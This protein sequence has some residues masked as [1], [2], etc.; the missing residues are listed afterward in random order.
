MDAARMTASPQ[1]IAGMP[2]RRDG[3]AHH[4]PAARRRGAA[5]EMGFERRMYELLLK[6]ASGRSDG[7]EGPAGR[8]PPAP[9]PAAAAAHSIADQHTATVRTTF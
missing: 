3:A 8:A 6:Y 9:P 4:S 5:W 7:P 1:T 2:Q